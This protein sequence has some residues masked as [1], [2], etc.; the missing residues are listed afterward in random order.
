MNF[1]NYHDNC[2]DYPEYP[3]GEI[4]T[5]VHKLAAPLKCID[6][7]LAIRENEDEVPN[8]WVFEDS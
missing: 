1:N 5:H 6:I 2:D 8:M 7:K 4:E 3:E